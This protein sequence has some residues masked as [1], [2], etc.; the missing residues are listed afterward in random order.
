MRYIWEFDFNNIML[1][2]DFKNTI[3]VAQYIQ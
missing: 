2:K 3:E 1:A